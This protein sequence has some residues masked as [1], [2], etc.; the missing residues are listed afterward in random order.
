MAKREYCF[1]FGIIVLL[2]TTNFSTVHCRHLQPKVDTI[3]TTE[4]NQIGDD[5]AEFNVSST[6]HTSDVNNSSNKMLKMK[7]LAYKL[8]SG[9]SKRGPG[10]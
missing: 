5:M 2:M 6:N 10:H 1:V 7:S 8:A 4:C 3:A 9:P